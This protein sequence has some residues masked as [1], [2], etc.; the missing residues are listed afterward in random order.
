MQIFLQ[1]C[2]CVCVCWISA[3]QVAQRSTGSVSLS[4]SPSLLDFPGFLLASTLRSFIRTGSTFFPGPGAPESRSQ[5]PVC[6]QRL[7]EGRVWIWIC[8]GPDESCFISLSNPGFSSTFSSSIPN[9][10]F[11]H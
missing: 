9:F 8:S 4:P 5:M 7:R 2:M 10:K 3:A 6:A 11:T 1:V